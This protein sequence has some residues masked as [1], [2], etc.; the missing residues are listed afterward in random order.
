[1][2]LYEMRDV[3]DPGQMMHVQA[4]PAVPVELTYENKMSLFRSGVHA[5]S[6]PSF[7]LFNKT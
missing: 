3:H 2:T 1:M 7:P 5:A 6:P 4:K